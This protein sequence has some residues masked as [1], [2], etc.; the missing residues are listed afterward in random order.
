M[1][2][3]LVFLG[4]S[5]LV[6]VAVLVGNTLALQPPAINDEVRSVPEVNVDRAVE[7]LRQAIR[8][9]TISVEPGE[10]WDS[11]PFIE[12]LG[13]LERN[14]PAF[15][16]VA[17]RRMIAG[18]TP[19]FT[20][21]GSDSTLKP[22]LLTAHYDVVPVVA[23]TSSDWRSPPFAGEVV[24]GYVYGRGALDDK[25]STI[26]LLEA[27]E[28]LAA[29]GFVP[30][31]TVYVSLGHDEEVGGDS[32]AGGVTRFLREQGVQ[33]A[34][35][36]D[37]GSFLVQG[38]LPVEQPLAMINVAEKGW[39]SMELTARGKGG[40]SSMPPPGTAVNTLADALVALQASP[41][42]GGLSGPAGETFNG[43]APY[44]PF[45]QRLLFANQWLFGGLLERELA[46]NPAIN[47]SLRTTMAPTM[48]SASPKENVLPI[49]ASAR[50]NFRLHPRDTRESTEAH[51]EAALADHPDVSIEI[52]QSE[53]ASAVS[54][55]DVEGYRLLAGNKFQASIVNGEVQ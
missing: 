44:L 6:L 11:A 33:L 41:L 15:H 7:S 1:R 43:V 2:K 40:H 9:R 29:S 55:S 10:P 23:G 13:F 48:L 49:E 35:S 42:P 52:L 24:D 53:N 19:L 22:L 50:V 54:S 36:L 31:R 16:A 32:G 26:T 5:V 8:Y 30:R 21:P 39:L 45:G 47:A 37:E 18:Y 27:V 20:W 28:V 3:I 51:V 17:E 14:Y 4:G 12:F 25:G 46:K 34:W 38:L